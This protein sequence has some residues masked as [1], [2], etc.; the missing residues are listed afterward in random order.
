MYV[1]IKADK[2]LNFRLMESDEAEKK[3][4]SFNKSY[5]KSY[6]RKHVSSSASWSYVRMYAHSGRNS[7][8]FILGSI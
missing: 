8:P 4:L 6:E 1:A 5:C 3:S 7:G 2:I